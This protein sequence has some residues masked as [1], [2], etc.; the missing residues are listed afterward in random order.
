[1]LP[2]AVQDV[3]GDLGIRPLRASEVCLAAPHGH[4]GRMSGTPTFA[5]KVFR[6]ITSVRR[7]EA[8]VLYARVRPSKS[9]LPHVSHGVR[10]VGSV[11]PLPAFSQRSLH[12]FLYQCSSLLS[13]LLRLVWS[14]SWSRACWRSCCW[15]I[16]LVSSNTS[17]AR[18]DK[19]SLGVVFA[20]RCC[21]RRPGSDVLLEATVVVAT[22][23]GPEWRTIL[24]PTYD[25]DK[26]RRAEMEVNCDSLYT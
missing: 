4:T 17:L 26:L 8:M 6:P 15:F 18:A 9:C 20:F 14:V 25:K 19:A 7:R 23:K 16:S 11:F 1:V 13:F 24:L 10:R 21:R 2:T 5:R 12:S 22:V 3:L